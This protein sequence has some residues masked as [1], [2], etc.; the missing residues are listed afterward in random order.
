[1]CAGFVKVISVSEALIVEG[2]RHIRR[3]SYP[4]VPLS[5][6]SQYQ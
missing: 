3:Q 5:T 2:A 1:M 6:T 4:N